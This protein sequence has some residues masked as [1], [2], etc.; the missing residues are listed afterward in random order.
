MDL[1]LQFHREIIEEAKKH[2]VPTGLVTRVYM[3]AYATHKIR[4]GSFN[5][6]TMPADERHHY[7]TRMHERYKFMRDTAINFIVNYHRDKK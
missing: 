3:E 1:C 7:Q 4:H 2:R 6:S 5:P